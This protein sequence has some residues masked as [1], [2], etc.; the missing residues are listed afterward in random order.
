MALPV[1]AAGVV[2][3]AVWG[4]LKAIIPSMVA[5]ALISLGIGFVTYYGGTEV[6]EYAID[7]VKVNLDG[8][9]A[10]A[11]LLFERSGGV[12]GLNIIFGGI[13]A[14]VTMKAARSGAT[15]GGAVKRMRFN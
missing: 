4:F 1:L 5:Y 15:A 13:I 10:N 3:S 11:M 8:I 2:F 12:K 6:A 7:Q 9:P 14:G